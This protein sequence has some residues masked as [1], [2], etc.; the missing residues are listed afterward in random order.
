MKL[1]KISKE[2]E[3]FQTLKRKTGSAGFTLIELLVVIAI[4]AILAAML[5]P[6]LASA[7]QKAHGIMCINNIKQ[8]TLCWRLYADDNSDILAPNEFPYMTAFTSYGNQDQMRN[9]V[10]GTMYQPLDSLSTALLLAPQTVLSSCNKNAKIFKCPADNLTIQNKTRSRSYSM[11]NAVGSRWWNTPRGGG[12][13]NFAVGSAVGGGWLSGT[14]MDPD[15]NYFRFGKMSSFVNPGPANTWVLMDENPQT[16]NDGLMAV[17]IPAGMNAANTILVD[18]PASS[19]N[20]AAGLSFADG[21]GEIHRWIDPRTYT[22]A[23]NA[24]PGNV[25]AS[26]SPNNGDVVWLATRTSAHR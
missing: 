8:I 19:H 21:H 20:R 11:S 5:L 9:W 15:P 3:G 26:P 18:Y 25:A 23:V 1:K 16:I 4:I 12:G 17:A 6:A 10:V 24:N 2:V 7:K 13:G 22:P 14:Y